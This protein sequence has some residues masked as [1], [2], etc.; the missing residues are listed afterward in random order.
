MAQRFGGQNKGGSTKMKVVIGLVV[1]LLFVAVGGLGFMLLASNS[2]AKKEPDAQQI[3]A[4]VG[5]TE[6]LVAANRI[7]EGAKLE[8]R[9]FTTVTLEDTKVPLGAIRRKDLP[10]II[11]KYSSRLISPNIPLISEDIADTKPINTLNIP[12]GF[13]AVTINVDSRTSVEGFTKP[14]TRV[15]VLWTYTDKGTQKV[16]TIV[17]FTK[18]L[19]VGG[20]TSAEDPRVVP[21]NGQ[22]QQ[23]VATTITLLVTEKEAKKVELA[24]TIGQ[25][26]LSLVGEQEEMSKGNDPDSVTVED[27]LGNKQPTDQVELS[28]D[29]VMY[30]ADPT[31]G[32]QIRWVLRNKRWM[33]DKSY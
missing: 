33:Q 24:R 29:G 7:E 21:N 15:D 14:N 22:G 17:R 11:T 19:S 5:M 4:P 31:T 2:E 16:A 10:Q 13:R 12:P 20:A 23:P 30:T 6:I 1:S 18:V 3:T 28:T 8:E 25:L 32:K 9:L 26:S 27:L